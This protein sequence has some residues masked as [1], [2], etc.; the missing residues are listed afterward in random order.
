VTRRKP[1][2]VQARFILAQKGAEKE[3]RALSLLL[4]GRLSFQ[5]SYGGHNLS[6]QLTHLRP[7]LRYFQLF[8]LKTVK[9]V[10]LIK[11]LAVYKMLIESI[12]HKRVLTPEELLVLRRKAKEINE[13][14]SLA[15][16]KVRPTK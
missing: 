12:A 6:V 5:K 9:R 13:I 15:D 16:D 8:P 10:S 1:Y 11:F 2:Q 3:L 4:G 7:T 14:G